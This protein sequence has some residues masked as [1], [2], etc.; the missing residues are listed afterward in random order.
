M[1][2]TTAPVEESKVVAQPNATKSFFKKGFSQLKGLL[3]SAKDKPAAAL[4][5]QT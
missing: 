2:L 4:N 3:S 5:D 1:R